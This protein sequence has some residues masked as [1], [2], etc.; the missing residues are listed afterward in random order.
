MVSAPTLDRAF[1]RWCFT[2]HRPMR[3][4][5][6][7]GQAVR[8]RSTGP[9]WPPTV[10]RHPR[11]CRV[12]EGRAL[13]PRPGRRFSGFR[14]RGRAEEHG[15]GWAM[16]HRQ[17]PVSPDRRPVAAAGRWRGT[18]PSDHAPTRR[19]LL[20]PTA[21]SGSSPRFRLWR[22]RGH[23]L[24]PLRT[25]ATAGGPD[26][27]CRVHRP[28][29]RLPATYRRHRGS[30]GAVHRSMLARLEGSQLKDRAQE[31]HQ[32]RRGDVVVG[33]ATSRTRSTTRTI[34]SAAAAPIR[35]EE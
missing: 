19:L 32:D 11:I 27:T 33:T 29:R 17:T 10:T 16:S 22:A 26:P 8:T 6:P 34:V 25:A 30:G 13:S 14:A 7:T 20:A 35:A 3:P 24:V 31:G 4:H 15:R 2:V 21:P 9:W 12:A 28:P 23:L 18:P 1:A 5:S